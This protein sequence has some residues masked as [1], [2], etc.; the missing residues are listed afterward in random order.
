MSSLLELY[1]ID[2]IVAVEAPL[3]IRTAEAIAD[4]ESME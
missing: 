4:G 3:L 1:A 2:E